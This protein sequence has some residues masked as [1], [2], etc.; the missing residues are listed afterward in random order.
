[1]NALK[2]AICC[3]IRHFYRDT[4][5]H[6]QYF[7]KAIEDFI[8]QPVTKRRDDVTKRV[9]CCVL[10]TSTMRLPSFCPGLRDL[11]FAVL[12]HQMCSLLYQSHACQTFSTLSLR[13]VFALRSILSSKHKGCCFFAVIHLCRSVFPLS[14]SPTFARV[15]NRKLRFTMKPPSL[16]QLEKNWRCRP[17]AD[18]HT[19]GGG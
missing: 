7:S 10:E 16:R 19:A 4:A 8:R 14:S 3:I 17:G 11:G 18:A 15:H 2:C 13:A 6:N 5:E 9:K 12:K 1:M